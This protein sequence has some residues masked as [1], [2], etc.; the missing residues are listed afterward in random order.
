MSE[1]V[2]S[3]VHNGR[4]ME[5]FA[6]IDFQRG[7][8]IWLMVFLHVFNHLYDYSWIDPS[9]IFQ[10][11]HPLLAVWFIVMAF[12]GAWAGYFVLISGI[13]TSLTAMKR[14]K[15]NTPPFKIFL[16]RAING[17]GILIAGRITE[18]FGYYGYFGRVIQSGENLLTLSPWVNPYSVSAI[19]R[20]IF[21]LEALQIIGWA[22]IIHAIVL[23]FILLNHGERKPTRN[24][25]ILSILTV[26]IFVASPFVWNYVDNLPWTIPP[27][28]DDF[29]TNYMGG[30]DPYHFTWP[31]EALQSV[32]ASFKTY[33]LVLIAGD[34]YPFFPFL[35]TTFIGSIVGII[36]AMDKPPK[37]TPLYIGICVFAIFT[38]A[39]LH[40]FFDPNFDITFERPNMGFYLIL[41]GC[42]LGCVALMLR[43]VEFRGRGDKFGNRAIIKYFRKWGIIAM[44]MFAIQIYMLVPRAILYPLFSRLYG[45]NTISDQF[46]R[47]THPGAEVWVLFFAVI[48]IL[49][50]DFLLWLWN[51][52]N[53]A[54]SY[55]WI[56]TKVTS[57][58][59]LKATVS[60]L[61]HREIMN[62][63]KWINCHI[64]E[65]K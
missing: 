16:K 2:V 59:G 58:R 4:R 54:G 62:E 48:T 61:N 51:K 20:R 32:N 23:F 8:A 1:E 60:R 47:G 52:I 25:I 40:I 13:V 34:L 57:G 64:P 9:T 43:L 46:L 39:V 5:R 12:L 49:S 10:V 56:I 3:Q 22:E 15:A 28:Y 26:I 50:Y 44:T 63:V 38:A 53:Y 11:V 41:L 33:L 65:K 42:Q 31:S 29:L 19:W 6:S 37:K 17:V 14:A 24:I 7:L 18:A 45:L 55:E 27:N 36:L 21:M 35:T 30:V